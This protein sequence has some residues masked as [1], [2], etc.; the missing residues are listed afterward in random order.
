VKKKL[1]LDHSLNK[2]DNKVIIGFNT[3]N[4]RDVTLLFHSDSLLH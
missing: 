2:I 1:R 3:N 4:E